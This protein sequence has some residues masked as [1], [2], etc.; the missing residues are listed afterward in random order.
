MI[1]KTVGTWDAISNLVLVS[2]DPV[3]MEP[4]PHPVNEMI[5]LDLWL[6][7]MYTCNF[8]Y[9]FKKFMESLKNNNDVQTCGHWTTWFLR[10]FLAVKFFGL[11]DTH[12]LEL[13]WCF[14]LV[15]GGAPQALL[16]W[17]MNRQQAS[18]VDLF[19]N[20]I[21]HPS[22]LPSS[23]HAHTLSTTLKSSHLMVYESIGPSEA[24]NMPMRQYNFH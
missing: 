3:S 4:F 8:A 19:R 15:L 12:D 5:E 21:R 10:A 2:C 13:Q 1:A 22:I 17:L 20:L 18:Y 16:G 6:L 23:V 7:G 11:Y 9:N 24:L 14:L